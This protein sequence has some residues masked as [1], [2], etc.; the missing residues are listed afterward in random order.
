MSHCNVVYKISCGDCDG[1]YVGQTKRRL[2]TRI[3][4]HKNDIN[5][6]S[7]SPSVI[8]AQKLDFGHEFEWDEVQILDE[9]KSYKKRLI[10][11]MV[12]IKK[13]RKPLNLQ[14]DTLALPEEYFPV[15]NLSSTF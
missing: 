15:L 2:S 6:K 5:K 7:G 13:Q 8:S 3:K 10:S 11:E 1:S 9:E 4:V 12:N 14:S